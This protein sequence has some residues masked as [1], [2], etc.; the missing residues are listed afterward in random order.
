MEGGA[1]LLLGVVRDLAGGVRPGGGVRRAALARMGLCGADGGEPGAARGA[2]DGRGA[3]P[4]ARA[5][6]AARARGMPATP[7]GDVVGAPRDLGQLPA[8]VPAGDRE[9]GVRVFVRG[10]G[11]G[12]I[13]VHCHHN[14]VTV[15][16][17]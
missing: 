3:D 12:R 13:L 4:A 9:G 15:I 6:G 14:P 8:R 10:A 2:G 7:F 5:A 16:P 11:G 17:P 1:A